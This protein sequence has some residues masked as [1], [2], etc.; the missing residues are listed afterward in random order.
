MHVNVDD[1][2][3][4]TISAR[5]KQAIELFISENNIPV[6]NALALKWKVSRASKNGDSFAADVLRI[7]IPVLPR[8]EN[9]NLMND[10]DKHSEF[11]LIAKVAP[12]LK[13][14]RVSTLTKNFTGIT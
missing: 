7:S 14:R 2:V 9:E 12:K 6:R 1:M 5:L 8:D 13:F 3:A 10:P 11:N 4:L